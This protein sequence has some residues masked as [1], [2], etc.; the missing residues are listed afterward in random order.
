MASAIEQGFEESVTTELAYLRTLALERQAAEHASLIDARQRIIAANARE[1]ELAIERSVQATQAQE[2]QAQQL[3]QQQRQLQQQREQSVQ[4]AFAVELASGLAK[5]QQQREQATRELNRLIVCRTR[6]PW[7]IFI[8][9]LG[10]MG[11][12]LSIVAIMHFT[13]VSS[14]ALHKV[15]TAIVAKQVALSAIEHATA[16]LDKLNERI[17][18]QQGSVERALSAISA[19]QA[20]LASDAMR[21]QASAKA[22]AQQ[23]IRQANMREQE[24][25]WQQGRRF[26]LSQDCVKNAICK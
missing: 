14:V 22:L 19:R 2:I 7:M 15:E 21:A 17:V 23:Q 11:L 4:H 26:H 9:A 5:L 20:Q 10:L 12:A 18:A 24:K 6:P 16:R 1:Q 3:L 25:K 13:H 8:T